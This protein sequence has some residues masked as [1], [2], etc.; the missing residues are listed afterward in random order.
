MNEFG[1]LYLNANVKH[2]LKHNNRQES[3]LLLLAWTVKSLNVVYDH[4]TSG[5]EKRF[6]K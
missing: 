5:K 3:N 6:K 4:F 1:W 2:M